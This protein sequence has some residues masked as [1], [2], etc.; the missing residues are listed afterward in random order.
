MFQFSAGITYTCSRMLALGGSSTVLNDRERGQIGV[1]TKLCT[2]GCTIGPPADNEYAVDPV[3]VDTI[4]LIQS[5]E[6]YYS[7]W[8]RF[9]EH[10]HPPRRSPL[11]LYCD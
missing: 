3:G 4:S 10:T 1:M 7:N 8:F 6:S 2:L 5:T 11:T 9:E